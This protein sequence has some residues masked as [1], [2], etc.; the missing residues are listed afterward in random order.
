MIRSS[1]KRLRLCGVVVA[2]AAVAGVVGVCSSANGAV[3]TVPTDLNIGDHYRL[4]FVTNYTWYGY[5]TIDY[6]NTQL[7][8]TA[9]HINYADP[10]V[11]ALGAQWYLLGS[12]GA[13]FA[14]DNTGTNPGVSTGVP[15]YRLDGQRIADNNA[16]L[17]DGTLAA[18]LN[19]SPKGT[20]P[21]NV[22][23]TYVWTGTQANGT[24][25]ITLGGS[26]PNLGNYTSTANWVNAFTTSNSSSLYWLYG[27]SEVLTVVPEP[28]SLAILSLA[29]LPATRYRRRR[30][31]R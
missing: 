18:P 8:N 27:I 21:P 9:N 12:T 22:G 3:V 16:D 4:A 11:I 25:Y 20:A 29:L 24:G 15:I 31:A 23:T 13:S 30:V 10:D 5:E 7:T 2:V 26:N 19:L 28:G 14:R 1:T 17:W 6:Y